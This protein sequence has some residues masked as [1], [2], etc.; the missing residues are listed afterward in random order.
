MNA[1]GGTLNAEALQEK[2]KELRRK[3]SGDVRQSI[4]GH[5]L[6]KILSWFAHKIGVPTAICDERVLHRVLMTSIELAQLRGT[7]LFDMLADW[8]NR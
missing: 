7:L 5:H 6:V 3:A 2:F 1:S 8:A 4:N